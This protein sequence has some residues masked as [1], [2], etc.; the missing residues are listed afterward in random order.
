MRLGRKELGG[1]ERILTVD[2][3]Q[4]DPV[5]MGGSHIHLQGDVNDT[6]FLTHLLR[7]TDGRTLFVNVC[8]DL[9]NVR[10]RRFLAGYDVAYLDSCASAIS[11]MDEYRFSRMMPHTMSLVESAYPHWLCWG[12]N[13]G[14]VEII[15]RKI[16]RDFHEPDGIYD[17]SIFEYDQLVKA[18][19]GNDT[20]AVGWCVGALVEEVMLSP[21]LQFVA[22]RPQEKTRTGADRIIAVWEEEPIEA[23]IVGHE[24]IW[25]LGRL[26]NVNDARF[27]YALQPEVMRALV[28]N[29]EGASARLKVMGENVPLAGLERVAVQVKSRVSEKMRTLVWEVD[30]AEI[31]KK[32]R[33]NGVQF[34]TCKSLLLALVLLQHTHYGTRAVNCCGSDLPI[35]EEDWNT[36]YAIM[37][38]LGIFWKEGEYLGLHTREWE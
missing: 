6:R 25:N 36:L 32:Y 11:G 21:T 34:Q 23:R 31:W 28:T 7:K 37:D 20:I 4:G 10:L 13:P 15:A 5:G 35:K 14:L 33:V 24:D 3:R 26:P 17:V 16:I 19:K 8:S 9:D 2:R 27:I 22:G 12:I 30:H 38:S 1:F 18:D 29:P